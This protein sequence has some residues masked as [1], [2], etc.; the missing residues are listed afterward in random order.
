MLYEFI[1]SEIDKESY[2]FE[3]VSISDVKKKFC[4]RISTPKPK[5]RQAYPP[6]Y[7]Q[8]RWKNELL[9]HEK[10]IGSLLGINVGHQFYSRAEMTTEGF[11]SHWLNGIDY[12]GQSKGKKEIEFIS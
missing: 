4:Y 9:Y 10:T 7:F 2:E 6:L 5:C 11:H 3:V 12:I 8:M 1:K